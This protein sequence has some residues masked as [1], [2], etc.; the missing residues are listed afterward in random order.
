MGNLGNK[1]YVREMFCSGRADL[2]FSTQEEA[3]EASAAA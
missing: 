3:R 1:Y 2:I